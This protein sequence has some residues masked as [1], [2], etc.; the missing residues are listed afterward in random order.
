VRE[1]IAVKT[2][3]RHGISDGATGLPHKWTGGHSQVHGWPLT[4]ARVAT[5]RCTGGQW[6]LLMGERAAT[7][8]PHGWSLPSSFI[9]IP[10]VALPQGVYLCGQFQVVLPNTSTYVPRLS[11]SMSEKLIPIDGDTRKKRVVS[12][13]VHNV[14]IF[15][16]TLLSA[17]FLIRILEASTMD[18]DIRA[19]MS[20]ILNAKF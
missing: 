5:H 10:P 18:L 7:G 11:T 15:L 16:I 19:S 12:F 17:I 20:V 8:P 3:A 1:K 6:V 2:T 4:G 9:N 13:S 14:G